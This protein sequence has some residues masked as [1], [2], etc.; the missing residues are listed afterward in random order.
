MLVMYISIYWLQYYSREFGNKKNCITC[1]GKM[2]V[3]VVGLR[4]WNADIVMLVLHI[5]I[6]LYA[7]IAIFGSDL[8]WNAFVAWIAYIILVVTKIGI[9]MVCQLR[10]LESQNL[11]ICILL[12]CQLQIKQYKV[13]RH[14]TKLHLIICINWWAKS[15]V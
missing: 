14:I 7:F 6:Y 8:K 13:N 5:S 15:F 4:R 12:F 2:N 3:Y 10:E 9:Q 1:R 11:L